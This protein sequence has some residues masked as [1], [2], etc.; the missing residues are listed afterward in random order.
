[1]PKEKSQAY[2][3]CIRSKIDNQANL[4]VH[5]PLLPVGTIGTLIQEESS[6]GKHSTPVCGGKKKEKKREKKE[7]GHYGPIYWTLI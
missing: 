2:G 6:Q 5:F 1:M 4:I 7:K 3:Q